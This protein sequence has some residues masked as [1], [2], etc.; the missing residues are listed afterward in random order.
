MRKLPESDVSG[1]REVVVQMAHLT[2]DQGYDFEAAWLDTHDWVVVPVENAGHFSREQI[3]RI[4]DVLFSAGHRS[5]LALSALVLPEPLPGSYELKI[6]ADDLRTFNAEC[7]IFRFLLTSYD[8]SW[9]ISCNEWFNL[10]A[11]SLE[12][13]EQMLGKPVERAREDFMGYAKAVEQ[14]PE[15]QLTRIA[16]RYE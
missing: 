8:L 12:L 5:C 7:G 1:L 14:T 4:V 15:G 9:A 3:D 2:H 10:Y 11:G 16:K 6:S 13:L